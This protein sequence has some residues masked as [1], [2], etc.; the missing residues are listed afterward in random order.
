MIREAPTTAQA[1]LL[2]VQRHQLDGGASTWDEHGR[3]I[4]YGY[5]LAG[6]W[7]GRPRGPTAGAAG[8]L[9]GAGRVGASWKLKVILSVRSTVLL[10]VC[11]QHKGRKPPP[12]C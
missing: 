5:N 11:E 2:A 4:C 6:L 1:V 7:L 9:G 12:E 8:E 3:P 10:A